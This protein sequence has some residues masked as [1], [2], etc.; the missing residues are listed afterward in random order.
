[1]FSFLRKTKI[2]KADNIVLY[3]HRNLDVM[4]DSKNQIIRYLLPTQ[5]SGIAG[6]NR[7]F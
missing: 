1:M 2:N 7:T 3:I 5:R 4:I 6:Q